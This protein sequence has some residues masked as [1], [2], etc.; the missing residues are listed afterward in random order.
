MTKEA[1]APIK[2]RSISHPVHVIGSIITVHELGNRCIEIAGEED[3]QHV[4]NEIV[5]VDEVFKSGV[6]SAIHIKAL[7]FVIISIADK[8]VG[9]GHPQADPGIHVAVR[10]EN[11]L[12]RG[13]IDLDDI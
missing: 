7:N 12:A 8:A 6:G 10:S 4:I 2:T 13:G 5:N 11:G 1:E 9:G 3:H